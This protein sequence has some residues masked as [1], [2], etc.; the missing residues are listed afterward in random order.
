MADGCVLNHAVAFAGGGPRHRL[1][2]SFPPGAFD[3]M[4]MMRN[5]DDQQ[6]RR[7]MQV[8]V[9]TMIKKIV[10][11]VNYSCNSI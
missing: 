10:E 6:R 5:C 7:E 9:V 3:G 4:L 8:Q 2:T 1:G 11:Y